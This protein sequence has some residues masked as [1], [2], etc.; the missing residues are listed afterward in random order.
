M[1]V[2]GGAVSWN[3]WVTRPK[4]WVQVHQSVEM[5]ACAMN[6]NSYFN[7]AAVRASGAVQT[8]EQVVKVDMD[9][10]YVTIK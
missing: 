3:D 1:I 10:R 8:S 7:N 4:S 9:R 5:K 6:E 2:S